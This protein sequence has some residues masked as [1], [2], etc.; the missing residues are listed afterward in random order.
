TRSSADSAF[1]PL[2]QYFPKDEMS[3]IPTSSR[4]TRHS[5]PTE[6][7]A[8]DRLRLGFSIAGSCGGAKYNGISMPKLTPNTALACWR[9]GYTGDALAGRPAGQS[10]FGYAI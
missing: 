5:P 7:N 3:S 6:S 8:F 10:S 2:T 4:A 1:G 9:A